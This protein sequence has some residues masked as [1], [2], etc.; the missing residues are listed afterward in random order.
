[1][2]EEDENFTG[3][4]VSYVYSREFGGKP[5]VGDFYGWCQLWSRW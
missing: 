2:E 3:K 5:G 1:M 4:I